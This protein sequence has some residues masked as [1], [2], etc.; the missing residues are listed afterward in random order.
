[1][2]SAGVHLV[3]CSLTCLRRKLSSLEPVYRLQQIAGADLNLTIGADV[4][5]PSTVVGDLGVLIVAE[6][7][8]QQH[9][10]KL[11]SSFFFQLRRIRE[12]RKRQSVSTITTC[13]CIHHQQ[14]GLL[15][16]ILTGLPKCAIRNDF[17]TPP[18]E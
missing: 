4:I 12:A 5:K 14:I 2:S 7:T 10:G 18:Q 1:M 3:D 11:S 9:V 15:T 8:F 16:G 13:P 6:L 17:R